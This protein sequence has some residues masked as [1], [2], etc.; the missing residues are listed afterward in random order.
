MT[1]GGL[2]FLTGGGN[3]LYAVDSSSGEELWSARLGQQGYANPMTYRGPDGR[4]F[5]VIATGR[6]SGTRL[7]AF[8][9]PESLTGA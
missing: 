1:G 7:M 4:Q 9:L 3:V 8:A 6:G 2:V 5:V